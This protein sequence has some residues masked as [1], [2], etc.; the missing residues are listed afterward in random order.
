MGSKWILAGGCVGHWALRAWSAR[1]NACGVVA[2]HCRKGGLSA[3]TCLANNMMPGA[4]R[5]ILARPCDSCGRCSANDSVARRLRHAQAFQWPRSGAPISV[6][7]GSTRTIASVGRLDGRFAT[8]IAL[9]FGAGTICSAGWHG[10]G[11]SDD[12]PSGMA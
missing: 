3:A 5:T 6:A 8:S 2:L 4:L 12:F 1:Q 9:A 11:R 10:G 7:V